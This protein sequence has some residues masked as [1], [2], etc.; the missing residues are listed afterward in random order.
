MREAREVGWLGAAMAPTSC[1][2]QGSLQ[3]QHGEKQQLRKTAEGEKAL[4]NEWTPQDED[5]KSLC[6]PGDVP[7]GLPALSH[8]CSLLHLSDFHTTSSWGGGEGKEAGRLW[9]AWGLPYS[10]SAPLSHKPGWRGPP[11]THKTGESAYPCQ[12]YSTHSSAW[13][14]ARCS[15]AAWEQLHSSHIQ[16]PVLLRW[17]LRSHT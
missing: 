17:P 11:I 3:W 8:G 4:G 7:D 15:I 6:K 12:H 2:A 16:A 14:G 13:V 9:Q 10:F 1:K 5:P